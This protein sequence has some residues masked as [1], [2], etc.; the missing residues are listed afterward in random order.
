M[1]GVLDNWRPAGQPE[2][3]KGDWLSGIFGGGISAAPSLDTWAPAQQPGVT[4]GGPSPVPGGFTPLEG[5]VMSTLS[6]VPELFGTNPLPGVQQWRDEHPISD[7]ATQLAG[8]AIPYAGMAKLSAVPRAARAL[9]A[10]VEGTLKAFGATAARSPIAS[11]ALKEFYRF[12]PLELSRLGTGFAIDADMGDMF[13]DVALGQAIAGTLGGLGGFLRAGGKAVAGSST[14]AEAEWGLLPNFELRIAQMPESTIIGPQSKEQKIYD[15]TQEALR[16]VPEG[17]GAGAGLKGRY[18]Y[19]VENLMPAD[20]Q[21]FEGNL[22]KANPSNASAE[23]V[24]KQA[25]DVRQLHTDNKAWSLGDGGGED[26]AKRAGFDGLQDLAAEMAYPRRIVVQD[27]R[28]GAGQMGA[29]MKRAHEAGAL[30]QIAPETWAMKEDGGLWTVMKRLQTGGEPPKPQVGKRGSFQFGPAKVRQGDEWLVGKMDNLGKVAPDA[31]KVARSTAEQWAK[32]KDPF[33]QLATV[34]PINQNMNQTMALLDPSDWKALRNMRRQKA[35]AQVAP[36]IS[37]KLKAMGGPADQET[38]R[39]I[40]DKLYD[41]VAPKAF[42]MSK[43]PVYGRF[44]SLLESAMHY[45]DDQAKRFVYGDPQTTGRLTKALAGDKGALTFGPHDGYESIASKVNMLSADELE[46]FK[47]VSYMQHPAHGAELKKMVDEGLIS[48]NA[49]A[50]IEHVQAVNKA[51]TGKLVMPALEEAG[52]AGEVRWLEGYTMPRVFKGDS[53]VRVTDEAGK[54]VY[55]ANGKTPLEAQKFANA[56]VEEAIAS[57]KKWKAEKAES[58]AFRGVDEADNID[59]VFKSVYEQMGQSADAQEVVARAVRKM[60]A[61]AAPSVRRGVP[62]P[63]SLSTLRTG[64]RGSVDEEVMTHE[65]VLKAIENHFHKLGRYAAVHTWKNR[66]GDQMLTWSK[67]GYETQF[68]DL[69]RKATQWLGVEGQLT[70]QLNKL[71]Q[72]VLG[73]VLGPKSATRIA[74]ATNKLMAN[75]NLFIL[76]P[77]F[78]V[79]NLLTPLQTVAPWI[80]MMRNAP[81][82]QVARISQ[83]ML[84]RDAAGRPTGIAGVVDPLKILWQATGL[85]RKPD[86]ALKEF[87]SRGLSDGVLAPQIYDEFVGAHA[88]VASGLRDAYAKSGW[89]FI[90]ETATHM[91]TRSEQ[92]SRLVAFNSAYIVGRDLFNL[93]GD[94]LYRFMRKGTETTMYG[95][96]VMDRSRLLTGPVG[97]TWGLFKNWQFHFIGQMSEYAGL[98]LKDKTFSPMLWQGASALSLGGLGATPLVMLADGLAKWSS[99]SPDSFSYM[100][101]NWGKDVADPLFF[102]L[103][104]LLGVSLQA[105]S[106]IPGTDVVQ[107]IEAMSNVVAWQRGKQAFGAIGAAAD[108]WQQTGQNPLKDAN[109]RDR[110]MSAFA[111]R[112]MFRAYSAME[113]DYV[114]SMQSGQPTVR[115]LPLGAKVL[116]GAGFNVTEIEKHYI[117]GEQLYETQQRKR[118]TIQA[119]GETMAQA[120]IAGDYDAMGQIETRAMASGVDV[121]SVLK[122]ANTRY[123]REVLGDHLSRFDKQDQAEARL[124]LDGE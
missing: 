45:V 34:N 21:W 51:F 101:E 77:T 66:F 111:P 57:G 89:E 93:S 79:L 107:D 47:M 78:A 104:A 30:Q 123:R 42:K 118:A 24:S 5:M 36:K 117:V 74:A 106:S 87:F 116:H 72:P 52:R 55:L 85:I 43:D 14:V 58:H 73:D 7:I 108:L 22:F 6:A 81:E 11:G 27:V 1:P 48:P 109:I 122:S 16:Y 54:S 67:K 70:T 98:A 13:A 32:L 61:N 69:H 90:K 10:G 28:A 100:Q 96:S 99:D 44:Y 63:K 102:G 46:Q 62:T 82:D 33:R 64:L 119:L 50:V 31:H 88:S 105:S 68:T 3:D 40:T 60:V 9:E 94:A 26:V 39:R 38:V 4:A 121:S 20:Q 113:G 91:S 114:R 115:D 83:Q 2:E 56:V 86:E 76:N 25:F 80:A 49:F 71:L 29:W 41:V 120:W 110:M 35:L 95:Y 65:D 59:E 17:R 84:T 75:W 97:S 18:L 112:A 8:I 15:L 12:T 23:T 37:E 124:L 103:P 19:D 53:F 92:W